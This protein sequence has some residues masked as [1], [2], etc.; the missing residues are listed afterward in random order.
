MP[1]RA[2]RRRARRGRGTKRTSTA[3][4]STFA[5][6][7]RSRPGRHSARTSRHNKRVA[8]LQTA[9]QPVQVYNEV[10]AYGS[11]SG[12]SGN[13]L[14]GTAL[15]AAAT[16]R[17]A[18]SEA[19]LSDARTFE[20]VFNDRVW[21]VGTL[22]DDPLY[23]KIIVVEHNMTVDIANSS[24]QRTDGCAYLCAARHDINQHPL[25]FLNQTM[26][27]I[28]SKSTSFSSPV[29][30]GF[31]P[32]K[33]PAFT[34]GYKVVKQWGFQLNPGETRTWRVQG[35]K[36]RLSR[37]RYLG[38]D[39]T[40]AIPVIHNIFLEGWNLT[41]IVFAWGTPVHVIEAG[42]LAPPADIAYEAGTLSPVHLDFVINRQIAWKNAFVNIPN[43]NYG[44]DNMP[45]IVPPL[46][47]VYDGPETVQPGYNV[48]ATDPVGNQNLVHAC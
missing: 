47:R 4:A 39:S 41:L 40:A 44:G 36:G 2:G 19:I 27:T 26:D 15:P 12:H 18:V 3:R 34:A 14:T 10:A 37:M 33:N 21:T 35:K 8:A 29:E 20:K 38:P 24:S 25:E 46:G 16:G 45:N 9:L 1:R 6:S 42:P 31:T 13:L 5:S 11:F 30:Y 48:I 22:S 28:P 23:Q 17:N 43:I 7:G 32:Y